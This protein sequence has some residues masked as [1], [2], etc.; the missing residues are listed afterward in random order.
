MCETQKTN[1]YQSESQSSV[2]EFLDGLSKTREY[3]MNAIES[4]EWKKGFEKKFTEFTDSI[5]YI[6]DWAGR[7]DNYK[8]S[9]TSSNG[10]AN[11]FDFDICKII[12]R[13]MAPDFSFE[14]RLS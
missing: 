1:E 7:L 8:I 12:D 9:H 2:I 11:I 6:T 14:T 3:G 13:D 5:G 10:I 4:D